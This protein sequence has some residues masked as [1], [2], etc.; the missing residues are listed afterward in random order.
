MFWNDPILY[1]ATFPYKDLPTSVQ[2]PFAGPAFLPWQNVPRFVPPFYGLQGM[3]MPHIY[4][5]LM[6][7]YLHTAAYT[8][9]TQPFGAQVPQQFPLPQYNV[10]QY[11]VPQY[12]LPQYNLPQYNLPQMGWNRPFGC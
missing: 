3:Q 7:P 4:N 5:Y 6:N 8:P 1:G 10:P 9:F 2:T 11:N 12:N